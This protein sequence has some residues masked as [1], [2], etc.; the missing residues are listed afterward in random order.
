MAQIL[1][2]ILPC[3]VGS[4][5]SVS[6]QKAHFILPRSWKNSAPLTHVQGSGTSLDIFFWPPE[7]TEKVKLNL[8]PTIMLFDNYDE[9]EQHGKPQKVTLSLKQM[10]NVT[11]RHLATKIRQKLQKSGW[12]MRTERNGSFSLT[13]YKTVLN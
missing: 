1:H 2:K 3:T 6:F 8:D 10:K 5:V 9:R 12:R 11:K 13:S 7:W 4:M